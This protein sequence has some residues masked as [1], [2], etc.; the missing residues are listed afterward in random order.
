MKFSSNLNQN[1]IVII[2]ARRNSK[3]IPFKNR[4]KIN[5]L[6]IVDHTIEFSESIN[7]KEI[8]LSTDD[9]FY[10]ENPKYKNIIHVRPD[11]LAKDET[12]IADALFYIVEDKKLQDNFILMLEPTCFPRNK[13]HLNCLVDGTFFNSGARSLASFSE[14]NQIKQKI[15]LLKNNKLIPDVDVWKRRQDYGKQYL[16]TGHYYGFYG[17]D[18]KKYYPGLC[19]ENVFPI[20]IEDEYVDINTFEDLKRLKYN[21]D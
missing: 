10:I 9:E 19:D 15:W 21:F 4:Y 7:P 1:L 12:L 6:T 8:I 2:P 17:G 5:G 20:F 14:T 11:Y 18:L 16:L 3:K 13:K